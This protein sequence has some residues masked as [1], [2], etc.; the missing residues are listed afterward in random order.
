MATEN[1]RQLVTRE[2]GAN[3]M[4]KRFVTE[5]AAGIVNR[6]S[7]AGGRVDGVCA[8]VSYGFTGTPIPTGDEAPVAKSGDVIMEAGAPLADGTVV[9]SGADGRPIPFVAGGGALSAGRIVNGGAALAIGDDC[10]VELFA[11]PQ[12]T[13]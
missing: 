6:T 8:T 5:A 3:V 1:I 4:N 11:T 10:T 13:V 2:S 9:M 7:V 12:A